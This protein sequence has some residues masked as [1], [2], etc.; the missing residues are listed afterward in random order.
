MTPTHQQAAAGAEALTPGKGKGSDGSSSN[1]NSNSAKKRKDPEARARRKALSKVKSTLGRL[2]RR[3]DGFWY[4]KHA[5]AGASGFRKRVLL[6]RIGSSSGRYCWECVWSV[7][8]HPRCL[9]G[10][11]DG[12]GVLRVFTAA[13]CQQ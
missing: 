8:V 6:V 9:G 4:S 5:F 13:M 7:V 2:Q 3:V 12:C 1:N 11:C 10:M